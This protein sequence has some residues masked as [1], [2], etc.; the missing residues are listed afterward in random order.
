MQHVRPHAT[1]VCQRDVAAAC[2]FDVL[3][4]QS[5]PGVSHRTISGPV[6]D[7]AST[8]NQSVRNFLGGIYKDDCNTT[9]VRLS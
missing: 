7:T 6:L 1:L 5:N 4:H 9:Y 8:G 2:G 3:H